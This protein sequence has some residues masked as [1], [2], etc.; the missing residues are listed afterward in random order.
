MKFSAFKECKELKLGFF[1]CPST[2]F[3]FAGFITIMLIIT[4]FVIARN[5]YSEEIVFL[6]T[7]FMAVVMLVIAYFVHNGTSKVAQTKRILQNSNYQLKEALAKLKKAE[8]IKEEFMNMMIHDLRSPLNGIRM[9][10]ELVKSNLTNNIKTDIDEPI[11][12]ISGSSKRMLAIVNDLLDVAKIEAGMFKCEKKTNNII[13]LVN[14]V[15]KYFSPLALNKKIDIK[16]IYNKDIPE[17]SFDQKKMRQVVEN[18]ISNSLKFTREGGKIEVEAFIH[19]KGQNLDEEAQKIGVNWH[20]KGGD[21]K[22]DNYERSLVLAV[23]DNGFGISLDDLSK[24]FNKFEQMGV[25]SDSR[26]KSTG[27]GLVIV[28]GVVEAHGGK[29]G[30][31]SKEG[32]GTTIYFNLPINN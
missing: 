18:L 2:L 25:E 7:V 17:F 24:L 11:N 20:L 27:L 6:L 1:E 4:T 12:L 9:V 28:K 13:K 3:L 14:D 15:I 29:I 31:A 8:K 5:Y 23:T 10:S 21:N 30:V 26:Q 22:L 16:F 32:K 19:K